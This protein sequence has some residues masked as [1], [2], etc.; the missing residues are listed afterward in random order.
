MNKNTPQYL[1]TKPPL[2]KKGK[3]SKLI[4]MLNKNTDYLLRNYVRGKKCPVCNKKNTLK[5]NKPLSLIVTC[6]KCKESFRVNFK[7]IKYE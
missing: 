5:Q 1:R 3:F 2:V 4:N 6:I 7:E